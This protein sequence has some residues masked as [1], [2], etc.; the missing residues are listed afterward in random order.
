MSLYL[1]PVLPTDEAFIDQLVYDNL[2]EQLYAWA[3]DP[4]IREPLLKMQVRGQRAS[5]SAAFPRAD[6]GI[7]VLDDCPIGRLI[8]DRGPEIHYLVDIVLRNENRGKGIG[9]W[10]LRAL[11]TEADLARKRLRLQVQQTN[12]AKELYLRLGFGII[13]DRQIGILMERQPGA[14]LASAAAPSLL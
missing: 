2:F 6:H 9:T 4:K 11:S 5:Y 3:W 10:L 7:I 13:E 8:V 12:R 14:L 1:R